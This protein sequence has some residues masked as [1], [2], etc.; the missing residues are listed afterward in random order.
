V[1]LL[2]AVLIGCSPDDDAA[3]R[4]GPTEQTAAST[5]ITTTSRA[6]TSTTSAAAGTPTTTGPSSAPIPQEAPGPGGVVTHLPD[7]PTGAPVAVLVHGGG[8][9]GGS[10]DL[11]EPLAEAL[12]DDGMVVFNASYRTLR[13]GGGFPA[14][15]DDVACAVRY[16]RARA[17]EVGA[18]R[19]VT[20]VGHSAGAHLSASVALSEDTFGG[21]CP[22]E[23]SS[24]PDRLVGLAGVYRID[25]VA[26]IMRVFLGGD[27]QAAPLAWEGADPFTHLT[28]GRA[29]ETILVHGLDDRIVPAESSE[30]FAQALDEAGAEAFVHLVEGGHNDVVA[31]GISAP[32]ISP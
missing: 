25:T 11:M 17:A 9:V 30:S 31:A 32:L 28:A 15:F 18:S 8:W 3:P 4:P 29:F 24:T 21:G 6:T 26:P 10:P 20:L 22:W 1:V 27:R 23:G 13:D 19:E 12:A 16:A 14:S 2:L 5:D 7:D